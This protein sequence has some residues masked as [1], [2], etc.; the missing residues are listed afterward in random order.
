MIA[1]KNSRFDLE[2]K[3]TVLF[4][5]GLLTASS[6]TLAAFAY[7]TPVEHDLEKMAVTSHQVT[8][9]ME[10]VEQPKI[11]RVVQQHTT[12][13]NT[14][15]QVDLNSTP[16]E[17]SEAGDNSNDAPDPGDIGLE[18]M[19]YK[20]GDFVNIGV[21]EIEGEII[22]IVDIEA[23]FVGG[24]PEMTKFIQSHVTYPEEAMLFGDQGTVY[25]SFVVEP[26]GS[27]T[28]IDIA[29]GVT[30]ALDREAKRVVRAFPNWTP[31]ELN[32]RKVRTRVRLPITFEFGEE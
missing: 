3:R 28:N 11:E 24:V 18:G 13:T 4:Q 30:P 9:E 8:F 12:V 27:I 14:Q 15:T 6:F 23:S 5:L 32:F 21:E 20:M 31:G 26:D 2:K 1:K 10:V 7:K 17:N 22:D 25:V 29:R 16:D 19:G